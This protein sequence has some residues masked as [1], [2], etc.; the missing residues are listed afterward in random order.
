VIVELVDY[1]G[2]GEA[3]ELG[4]RAASAAEWTVKARD[5]A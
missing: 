4:L 3:I 5:R 1:V 2:T